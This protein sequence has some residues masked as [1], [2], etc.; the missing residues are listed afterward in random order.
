MAEGFSEKILKLIDPQLVQLATWRKILWLQVWLSAAQF[1]W[2][3]P[4]AF[5]DPVIINV[6]DYGSS[7]LALRF[8]KS[9]SPNLGLKP[10]RIIAVGFTQAHL[11]ENG[12][13]RAFWP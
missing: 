1:R 8:G 11:F 10:A 12:F 5:A 13:L 6:N 9:C 3:M 2:P 7:R 4:L